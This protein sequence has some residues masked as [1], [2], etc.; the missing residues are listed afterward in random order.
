MGTQPP[1]L[2]TIGHSTRTLDDFLGL[3]VR[4]EITAL[5]DVRRFAASRKYPHFNHDAL[6]TSLAR[7]GFEYVPMPDLGGRRRPR[8]IPVSP[9]NRLSRETRCCARRCCGCR[10]A[11][12]ARLA[13][14]ARH[15]RTAVM[16]SEAVWW[17]CHRALIADCL[18]AAGYRVC[19]ILDARK[20]EEH[21]YTSAARIENGILSYVPAT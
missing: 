11:A 17:R 19:H 6:D 3:L 1:T 2:W 9:C 7:A 18:K 20:T 13:E 5:V 4:H 8:D 14:L 15:K 10:A 21:P 16:C 12:V